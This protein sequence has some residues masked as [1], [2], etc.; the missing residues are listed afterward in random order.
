MPPCHG[1]DRRFE[2]GRAR[3]ALINT[4]FCG[5]LFFM[6]SRTPNHLPSEGVVSPQI[7]TDL[8]NIAAEGMLTA[9][10]GQRLGSYVVAHESGL[11]IKQH[12]VRQRVTHVELVGSLEVSDSVPTHVVT[13][14]VH[15]PS[16]D[17]SAGDYDAG[18]AIF[19]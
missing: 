7:L 12:P 15:F 17:K 14:E 3:Q 2:S 5:I 8:F 16:K 6:T 1:G 10:E 18:T 9:G 13:H 19:E 11:G 4:T